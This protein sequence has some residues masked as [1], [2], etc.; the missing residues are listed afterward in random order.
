MPGTH[1]ATS[2]QGER[3]AVLGCAVAMACS[4]TFVVFVGLP[5]HVDAWEVPGAFQGLWQLGFVLGAFLGPVAAGVAASLSGTVLWSRG[6]DLTRR[7][8]QLHWT[9]VGLSVLLIVAYVASSGPLR[10][11]LD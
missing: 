6:E 4:V 11:W 9:T 10:T 5:V 1:A 8:R 3:D 7:A 2:R